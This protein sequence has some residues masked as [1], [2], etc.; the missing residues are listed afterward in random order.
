M[1]VCPNNRPL[2]MWPIPV[3]QDF[4]SSNE[5]YEP[6][7]RKLHYSVPSTTVLQIVITFQ[8]IYQLL[9]MEAP[10]RQ[11]EVHLLLDNE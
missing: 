6:R 3:P 1:T 2:K 10:K 7:M 9:E 4:F 8:D 11:G 5:N